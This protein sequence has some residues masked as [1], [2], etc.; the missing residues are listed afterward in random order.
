MDVVF[1]KENAAVPTAD[2]DT[3]PVA[4]GSHWPANDPVVRTMPSLFTKDP[5]YGMHYSV[6]PAGYNDEYQDT[7]VE[8]ATR[9]PGEK[10]P[11]T[12]RNYDR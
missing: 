5:R 8:T 4:K 12:R 1:A 7:P 3:V 9:A 6:E 11:Y 2:G 10:R